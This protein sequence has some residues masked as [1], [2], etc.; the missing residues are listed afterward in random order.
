M[1]SVKSMWASSHLLVVFLRVWWSSHLWQ[2]FSALFKR[3]LWQ[4]YQLSCTIGGCCAIWSTNTTVCILKYPVLPSNL[5][6]RS[7]AFIGIFHNDEVFRRFLH[8]C[9]WSSLLLPPTLWQTH[10]QSDR[11]VYETSFR[12]PP[13]PPPQFIWS[14][15]KKRRRASSLVGTTQTLHA[16]AIT[17]KEEEINFGCVS[18]CS[19]HGLFENNQ[20]KC[21]RQQCRPEK[22]HTLWET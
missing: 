8:V 5:R 18:L 19:G 6:Q 1:L 13:T 16:P 4:I 17:I 15:A 2:P 10:I 7:N 22:R 3:D 20:G 21:A 12:C 14:K 11:G 9:H